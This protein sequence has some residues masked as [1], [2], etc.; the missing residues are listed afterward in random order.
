MSALQYAV[1]QGAEDTAHGETREYG[2]VHHGQADD[3]AQST[4][5]SVERLSGAADQVMPALAV[6]LTA[7]IY[8][9]HTREPPGPLVDFTGDPLTSGTDAQCKLEG[10][11]G[12]E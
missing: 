2:I 9:S 4:E 6:F 3:A 10:R 12:V 7:N 11:M 8:S 5:L 1:G